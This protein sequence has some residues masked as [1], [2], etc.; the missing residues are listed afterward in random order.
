MPVGAIIISLNSV[1]QP[2]AT[3]LTG[4]K[5]IF[6]GTH[7]CPGNIHAVIIIFIIMYTPVLP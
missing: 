2:H 6:F 7:A 4:E 5:I 3:L 1:H